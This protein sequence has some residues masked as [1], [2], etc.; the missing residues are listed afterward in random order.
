MAQPTASALSFI[1]RA[2]Q[3][4]GKALAAGCAMPST[5]I[6]VQRL[7]THF[8]WVGLKSRE[9]YPGAGHEGGATDG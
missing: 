7:A 9:F 4:Q 5:A 1:L 8:L 3:R 2:P 6:R